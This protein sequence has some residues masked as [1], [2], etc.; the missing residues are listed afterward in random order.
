VLSQCLYQSIIQEH[1]QLLSAT[2][3]E[4]AGLHAVHLRLK[5]TKP[6]LVHLLLQPFEAWLGHRYS[7]PASHAYMTTLLH[8]RS[9]EKEDLA[10]GATC[11]Q[12]LLPHA[13]HAH[14]THPPGQACMPSQLMTS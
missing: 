3:M 4:V 2:Y 10:K 1:M 5:R 14:A 7:A 8:E 12:E 6:C 9:N 13:K 11:N